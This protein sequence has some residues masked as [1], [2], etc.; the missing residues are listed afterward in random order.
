MFAFSY[1]QLGSTFQFIVHGRNT[2]DVVKHSLLCCYL[3]SLHFH[4]K[5]LAKL[6]LIIMDLK[7]YITYIMINYLIV[8][9]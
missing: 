4:V 1:L 2:F 6:D 5:P 3:L 7:K 9:E 8:V